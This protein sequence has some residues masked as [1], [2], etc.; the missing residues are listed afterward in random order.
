MT[1]ISVDE[2]LHPTGKATIMNV[3]DGQ[4]RR[5]V[6]GAVRYRPQDLLEVEHLVLPIAHDQ[7]VILYA[8]HGP[9][10]KL[11]EIAEKM[12]HQGFADVRVANTS[13]AD[14]ESRGGE[15][16]EPSIEQV[17][18]PSKPTEGQPLDRRV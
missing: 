10:P 15:T 9:T 1:T 18:A 3:G 13:F 2:L 6:R 11:G 7:A 16:Q 12:A 4:G 17:V 14:Y 5:E 8:E